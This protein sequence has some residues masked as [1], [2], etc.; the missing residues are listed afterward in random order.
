[1]AKIR[2][3]LIYSSGIAF[4]WCSVF[5]GK[6]LRSV[7]CNQKAVKARV[8]GYPILGVLCWIT[9]NGNKRA[10]TKVIGLNKDYLFHFWTKTTSQQLTYSYS[11]NPGTIT[12]KRD[13]YIIISACLVTIIWYAN[14]LFMVC[15]HLF[16]YSI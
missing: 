16:I 14:P 10:F 15:I 2:Q 1:M 6:N 7:S 12:I 13:H 8:Y 5:L 3:T 4:L 9:R 11:I